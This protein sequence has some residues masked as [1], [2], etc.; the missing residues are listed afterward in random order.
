MTTSL[1][2]G[3]HPQQGRTGV[4]FVLLKTSPT[5]GE[6]PQLMGELSTR[7]STG[8][9][10]T[11]RCTAAVGDRD[12]SLAFTADVTASS[13]VESVRVLA[14][15]ATSS[16]AKK[17][18]TAKEMAG[19]ESAVCK[20][21]GADTARCAYKVIVSRADAVGS[22]AVARGRPGHREGR[23]DDVQDRGRGLHRV[24][25]MELPSL[26][27]GTLVRRVAHSAATLR[28]IPGG[29][30]PGI[31][32]IGLFAPAVP[33]LGLHCATDGLVALFARQRA[34]TGDESTRAARRRP[35]ADGDRHFVP[36]MNDVGHLLHM[37]LLLLYVVSSVRWVENGAGSDSRDHRPGS[38]VWSAWTRRPAFG[39]FRSGG[40]PRG[41]CDGYG[42]SPS[43]PCWRRRSQPAAAGRRPVGPP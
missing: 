38:E 20:P 10:S 36:T 1:R 6:R 25:V 21:S 33:P 12:G 13:G 35:L 42:R 37:Y 18:P 11:V 19:E 17:G 39:R 32:R 29:A 22:G 24:K 34:T 27:L 40:A 23:R 4:R 31:Q 30:P 43:C 41:G 9:C 2:A 3:R 26:D 5:R 15:P 14:W 16:L 8:G 28:E 7:A